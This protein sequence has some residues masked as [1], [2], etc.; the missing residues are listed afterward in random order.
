[1]SGLCSAFSASVLPMVRSTPR[2]CSPPPR[3][4]SPLLNGSRA[5]RSTQ[6]RTMSCAWR[7]S[8]CRLRG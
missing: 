8:G 5:I 1:M 7:T 6:R 4:T 3:L 2:S